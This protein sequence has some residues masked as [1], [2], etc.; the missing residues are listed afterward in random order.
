MGTPLPAAPTIGR[1]AECELTRLR[2]GSLR[3]TVRQGAN[4][5]AMLRVL[6]D[7]EQFLREPARHIKN[8][9]VVTIARVPPVVPGQGR[10]ILR[11]INY[12]KSLHR[13]RDFFR[14][15]RAQ[16]ALKNSLLLEQAGVNTPRALAAC[17]VRVL[18]WP[19]KAY[20]ITEEVR[21]ASTLAA[22]H[23][24]KHGIQRAAAMKV[25]DLIA[26]LHK[27]ALSHG[28]LKWTNILLDRNSEAWLIDLDGVEQ[29][30]EI[31][32]SKA[33]L[34][35]ARLGRCFLPYP[36]TLRWS[37]SRFLK[38]YCKALGKAGEWRAWA[39]GMIRVLADF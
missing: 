10:L 4:V 18:F 3:W 34:D 27:N 28:D 37:G 30:A 39:E 6:Q 15:S 13:V 2:F 24:H 8:S 17:D 1:P 12:G 14:P 7:P 23:F 25:A 35:I 20:L 32:E 36:A 22:L 11:R 33:Q 9:R 31:S 29:F 38:Q 26:R 19:R 21:G 16:R 5:E